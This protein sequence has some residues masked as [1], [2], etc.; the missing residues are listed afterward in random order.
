MKR[1]LDG[2]WNQPN[3]EINNNKPSKRIGSED[4]YVRSFSCAV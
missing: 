1:V 2:S 3:H 4:H